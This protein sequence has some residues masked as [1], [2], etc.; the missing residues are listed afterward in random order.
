MA[1]V[2]S[3]EA[4]ADLAKRYESMI[5][6]VRGAEVHDYL[7]WDNG[8]LYRYQTPVVVEP[9]RDPDPD[10]GAR[11]RGPSTVAALETGADGH[12][13]VPDRTVCLEKRR[14]KKDALQNDPVVET[15]ETEQAEATV[16]R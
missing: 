14:A 3:I 10:G 12:L 11:R 7:V 4:L 5:M 2:L 8:L 1:D 13:D 9:E 16:D 6:H 15:L